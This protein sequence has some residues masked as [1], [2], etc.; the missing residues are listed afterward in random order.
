[1]ITE[2]IGKSLKS[3]KLMQEQEEMDENQHDGNLSNMC[4]TQKSIN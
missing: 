1:M 2:S 3:R 4:L